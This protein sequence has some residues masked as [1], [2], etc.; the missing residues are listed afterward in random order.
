MNTPAI[1]PDDLERKKRHKHQKTTEVKTK[2][3]KNNRNGKHR[4]A[5]QMPKKNKRRAKKTST[6]G[7]KIPRA[8]TA[9][10]LSC[11]TIVSL[12][13]T[14]PWRGDATGSTTAKEAKQKDVL[15]DKMNHL[16]EKGML[17]TPT[18]YL[19]SSE[20]ERTERLPTKP[21][22]KKTTSKA[23][24][25]QF[26]VRVIS[27]SATSRPGTLLPCLQCPSFSRQARLPGNCYHLPFLLPWAPPVAD[28]WF[29]CS[30]SSGPPSYSFNGPH[31]DPRNQLG[32]FRGPLSGVKRFEVG[33]M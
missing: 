21:R 1:Y 9:K 16:N 11:P 7:S 15:C 19:L 17:V 27:A 24:L 32:M 5:E 10:S 28:G 22:R 31:V 23:G 13:C 2:K 14:L 30:T 8:Y 6:A 25:Q 29:S 33:E 4:K 18:T 26:A 20:Q 3:Q 12:S